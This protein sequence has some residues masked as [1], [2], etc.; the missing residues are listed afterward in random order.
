M[1]LSSCNWRRNPGLSWSLL[2]HIQRRQPQR[3][4]VISRNRDM[5]CT[6]T[7]LLQ[8]LQLFAHWRSDAKG[9]ISRDV[10]ERAGIV[11]ELPRGTEALT[12]VRE[13]NVQNN[14][15]WIWKGDLRHLTKWSWSTVAL[16]QSVIFLFFFQIHT[17]IDLIQH[18]WL[19]V[20]R[21]W[22]LWHDSAFISNFPRLPVQEKVSYQF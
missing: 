7:S 17:L 4:R 11:G 2:T 3:L 14:E 15:W 10:T 9:Q 22:N 5:H 8:Q 20:H 13:Y 21:I 18:G 16:V 19:L 1:E 12:K 6:R